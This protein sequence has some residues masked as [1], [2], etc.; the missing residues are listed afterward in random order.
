MKRY[1]LALLSVLF[2]QSCKSQIKTLDGKDYE[3]TVLSCVDYFELSS[4]CDRL[5]LFE[6]MH[7]A[8]INTDCLG[9]I[10]SDL[11][12][13][14]SLDA[15]VKFSTFGVIYGS[16]EDYRKDLAKWREKLKCNN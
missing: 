8:G 15:S 16:T 2:F 9:E 12:E 5:S 14:T 13:E 6:K 4:Y 10:V 7:K 3:Q 1:I 11:S